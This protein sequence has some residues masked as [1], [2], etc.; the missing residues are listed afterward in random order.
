M[1]RLEAVQKRIA[2]AHLKDKSKVFNTAR[3]EALELD[4]LM[5]VAKASAVLATKRQESRGAHSR[6]D[7]PKRDDKNWQKHSIIFEDGR[8]AYRSVNMSPKE[9]EPIPLSESE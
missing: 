2:Q 9:V 7:F 6:L 4:N 5:E 1:G 3:I 8:L